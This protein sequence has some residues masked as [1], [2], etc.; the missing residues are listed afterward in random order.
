MKPVA[1]LVTVLPLASL[2]SVQAESAGNWTANIWND[3][4]QAVDCASCQV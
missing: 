2:P 3:F 4:K 1:L